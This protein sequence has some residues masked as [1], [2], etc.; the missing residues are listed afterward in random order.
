MVPVLAVAERTPTFT[1]D[2]VETADILTVPVRLF[3]PDAPVEVVEEDRDG[4]LL[5]YGCYPV[6]GHRVW[7]ATG[8]AVAQLGAVLGTETDA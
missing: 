2:A 3:L 6:A 1:P 8:R 7:G 4:W 5:R